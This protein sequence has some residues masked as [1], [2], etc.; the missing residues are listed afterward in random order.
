MD[1]DELAGLLEAQR[2]EERWA[3]LDAL[4]AAAPPRGVPTSFFVGTP[5]QDAVLEEVVEERPPGA[6]RLL[7]H[8][9]AS[10]GRA[11]APVPLSSTFLRANYGRAVMAGLVQHG[12]VVV[13]KAESR[14]GRKSREYALAPDLFDRLVAAGPSAASLAARPARSRLIDLVT[15]KP[16]VRRV[17]SELQT[18]TGAKLPPL[19]AAGIRAVREGRF[20]AGHVEAHLAL[21]RDAVDAASDDPDRER[22]RARYLN[23]L[24]CYHAVLTQGAE[25]LDPADSGGVWIYHPAYRM[26]ATGRIGAVGGALQ[27]CSRALKQA[28]YTD[29]PGAVNLDLTASQ[30][31][32]LV[33]EM[34]EAGHPSAWLEAYVADPHAK[35]AAARAVGVPVNGWKEAFYALLMGARVPAPGQLA[36]SDGDLVAALGK[37]SPGRSG[38]GVDPALY[39]RFYDYTEE[40]RG[41]L[42]AWRAWLFEVLIPREAH[43]V[44]ANDAWYLANR[45]GARTAF[46]GRTLP[47]RTPER[48][49]ALSAF[50]LQGREAALVHTVASLGATHDYEALSHEHDGLVVVGTVPDAAVAAG[51]EA[52]GMPLDL[53]ELREKPFL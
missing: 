36:R 7:V 38:G 12:L 50:L 29:V 20:H 24:R 4:P 17:K 48:V 30:A 21:L 46:P 33:V 45:A 23:D 13:E 18:V 53:V 40:L 43:Y 28:A 49:S 19:V 9:F 37:A 42:A 16:T 44:G 8:I 14:L 32:A 27:A 34:R 52:A 25:P 11:G 39:R 10:G 47:E 31:R 41:D 2:R 35:L 3:A 26:Q 5:E 51:A 15:G 1:I 6:R 22:A